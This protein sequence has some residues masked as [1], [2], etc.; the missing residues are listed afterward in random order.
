[1]ETKNMLPIGFTWNN[2]AVR[3]FAVNLID[4]FMERMIHNDNMRIDR[5]QTW[6]ASV[7]SA[8]L[9]DLDGF[10]VSSD[11]IDSDGKKIPD[12]V[13]ALSLQDAG[14]VLMRGHI[15]TFGP[16]MKRQQAK[17]PHCR[18][19][20][21]NLEIDLSKLKVPS[22]SESPIATVEAVLPRGWKRVL[23]GGRNQKELGWE[24]ETFDRF[25]IGVPTVGDALRNEPHFSAARILDFNARIVNDRLVNVYS[26]KTKFV[27][28][29]E[30][31]E[32]Y[33]AGFMFFADRGGLYADDR[34]AVRDAM[35]G[36]PQVDLISPVV[37]G[38]CEQTFDFGIRLDNFFPVAS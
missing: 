1:M 25:V 17:C 33:K 27:M 10:T 19:Q 31:F 37:C 30:M 15:A 23:D 16:I 21:R 28:P 29:N 4:G 7:L 14:L 8:L 36:L 34:V 3:T 38:N 12:I 2:K 32:S 13:K 5:P 11:F 24:N 35:N 22:P 18:Q 26:S 9:H 6:M 20:N